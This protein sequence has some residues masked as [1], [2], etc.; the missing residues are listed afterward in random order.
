ML[1]NHDLIF[2]TGRA[3]YQYYRFTGSFFKHETVPGSLL[4]N[5]NT[6]SCVSMPVLYSVLLL[7]KKKTK[8]QQPNKT[9]KS[10]QLPF[11]FRFQ[12]SPYF[13]MR[14]KT[15]AAFLSVTASELW[16]A[17]GWKSR[18]CSFWIIHRKI[19]E[20]S[21]HFSMKVKSSIKPLIQ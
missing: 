11:S 20:P 19:L 16:H 15:E 13:S 10:Q 5:L 8:N 4:H 6:S 1:W 18:P 7:S 14:L 2:S 21:P 12:S 9:A 3:Q 17:V